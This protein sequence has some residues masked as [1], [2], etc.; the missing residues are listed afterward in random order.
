MIRT[1]QHRRLGDASDCTSAFWDVVN[2]ACWFSDPLGIAPS[3]ALNPPT[4]TSGTPDQQAACQ[5]SA[6]AIQQQATTNLDYTAGVIPNISSVPAWAWFA[7]AAVLGL[8]LLGG[9]R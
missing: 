9:H 1:V 4:C 5:G 6:A 3:L 8:A 7:G 2:P